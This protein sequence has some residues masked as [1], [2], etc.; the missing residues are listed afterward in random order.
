[1]TYPHQ[2]PASVQAA[3]IR[4]VASVG[5]THGQARGPLHLCYG[6]VRPMSDIAAIER[7]A[8]ALDQLFLRCPVRQWGA[9][10]QAGM[11]PCIGDDHA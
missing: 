4:S 9:A 7:D 8:D 11:S 10:A 5:A 6:P 1:M 3:S 2:M